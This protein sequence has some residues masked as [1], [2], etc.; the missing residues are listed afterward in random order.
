M[1]ITT[2]AF[3]SLTFIA[4]GCTQ[5][6][7]SPEASNSKSVVVREVVNELELE[8]VPGTVNDVWVEPMYSEVEVPGSI[9]KSGVYYRMPHRTYYETVPGKFQKVEYPDF[10]GNYSSPPRGKD[11]RFNVGR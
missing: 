4:I 7:S 11:E 10:D 9:D 6:M 5:A 3:L 2:I 1:K 8:P